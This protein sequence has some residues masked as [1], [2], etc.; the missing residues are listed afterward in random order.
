MQVDG[1]RVARGLTGASVVALA[2]LIVALFVAG[3]HKNAQITNL[4]RHGIPIEVT[5]SSCL[6]AL[7]GS[8]SNAAGY[9][10]TGTFVLNGKRYRHTIPGGA[11][12]SPGTKVQMVTVESD[13]GLIA[14]VHQAQSEH[15]SWGPFV[16]PTVLLLVLTTLVAAVAVRSMRGR[17]KRQPPRTV[18]LSQRQPA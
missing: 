9:R 11:L 18:S 12:L 3:A 13:P 14:T 7:G 4:R 6:G 10:C 1:R 5:V 8:G 2:A 17:R 15:T 16:L